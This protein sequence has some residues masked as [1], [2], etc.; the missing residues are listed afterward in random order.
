MK[1]KR[2]LRKT[3][4]GAPRFAKHGQVGNAAVCSGGSGLVVSCG[5]VLWGF[6]GLYIKRSLI[7]SPLL[8]IPMMRLGPIM[9]SKTSDSEGY[10]LCSSN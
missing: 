1:E 9:W 8:A 3:E 2:G 10:R 4:R 6:G 5:A 7:Y